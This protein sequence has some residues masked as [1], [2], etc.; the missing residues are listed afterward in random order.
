MKQPNNRISLSERWQKRRMFI[1]S[2]VCIACVLTLDLLTVL[3][4]DSF[5]RDVAIL[6]ESQEIYTVFEEWYA[7]I[8]YFFSVCFYMI[9]LAVMCAVVLANAWTNRFMTVPSLLIW[10][11]SLEILSILGQVG[12]MLTESSGTLFR[13]WP[14]GIRLCVP[15]VCLESLFR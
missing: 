3:S 12:K 5:P 15:D 1:I 9:L 10:C 13:Y 4:F 14:S 7:Y 2:L 8:G 11:S 6:A